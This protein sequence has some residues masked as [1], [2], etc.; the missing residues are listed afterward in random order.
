MPLKARVILV[1]GTIAGIA[2][3]GWFAVFGAN[4]SF[5]LAPAPLSLVYPLAWADNAGVNP[6]LA[7]PLLAGAY[8][9][10]FLGHLVGGAA[11]V[12]R[13]SVL[14]FASLIA[15][16]LWFWSSAW[17]YGLQYQG[18]TYTVSVAA[19]NIVLVALAMFVL[20]RGHQSASFRSNYCFHTLLAIWVCWV[21]CPWLGEMP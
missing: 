10:L 8:G 12:P 19:L 13:V 16:N 3:I 15:G 1:L 18:G 20:W 5:V 21:S 7:I 4:G 9:L 6:A 14:V 2:V 17:H 11:R